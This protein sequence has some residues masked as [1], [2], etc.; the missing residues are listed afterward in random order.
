MA[1][2]NFD[3]FVEITTGKDTLHYTVRIIFQNIVNCSQDISTNDP[4]LH[5]VVENEPSRSFK[6]RR[7][8]YDAFTF[9]LQAYDKRPKVSDTHFN[10]CSK[11][12][13]F[14]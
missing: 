4:F 5:N 11:F 13:I 7:R 10:T 8:I 12:I 14:M 9:E 3:R 2:N 1:F 6:K